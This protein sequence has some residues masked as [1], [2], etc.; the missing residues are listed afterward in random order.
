MYGLRSFTAVFLLG[1]VIFLC[2]GCMSSYTH[3]GIDDAK[4][5][6]KTNPNAI[7]LDVRTPEEFDKKHIKGA[8]LL[9]IEN[10]RS[11]NLSKLPDKDR[12]IFVYCWT[13]RR[14][15]DAAE[16]LTKRGYTKVYDFGG[17]IDWT[18]EVEGSDVK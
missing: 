4:R 13:G 2:A 6:M 17:L 15:E 8:T 3:L 14:A 18:G 16:L 10:L 7:I 5:I 12:P 1:T 11:G 9:P